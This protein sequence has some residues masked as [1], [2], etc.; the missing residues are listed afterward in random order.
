M[1]LQLKLVDCKYSWYDGYILFSD[2]HLGKFP[3]NSRKAIFPHGSTCM[4]E[5]L[6]KDTPF[7][8]DTIEFTSIQRLWS[9]LFVFVYLQ[10]L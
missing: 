6:I 4:V 8:K 9:W 10:Y 7:I 1:R 2:V 5:P 3:A